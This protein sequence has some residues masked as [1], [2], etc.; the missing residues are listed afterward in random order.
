MELACHFFL[1]IL[2]MILRPLF[3]RITCIA[4]QGINLQM[5]LIKDDRMGFVVER[6][7]NDVE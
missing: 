4:L 5:R 2:S 7:T 1:R 6:S 3:F